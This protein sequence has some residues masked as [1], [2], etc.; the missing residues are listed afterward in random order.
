MQLLIKGLSLSNLLLFR[1]I[2]VIESYYVIYRLNW[3]K[4]SVIWH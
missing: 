1:N 2:T 4:N 3:R